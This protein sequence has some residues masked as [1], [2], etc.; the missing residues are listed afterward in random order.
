MIRVFLFSN[1]RIPGT[2]FSRLE[3]TGEVQIERERASPD[4]VLIYSSVWNRA[5]LQRYRPVLS[6]S[7]PAV[8]V[9]ERV[10]EPF[11][12]ESVLRKD[13]A[14]IIPSG[15]AGEPLVA[16]LRAAKAG[17]RIFHTFTNGKHQVADNISLTP[18]E[19]EVLTLIADG[20]G[21]KTIAAT[22]EISEHTVKFHISS[23]FDKLRVSTRT[24][25]VKV[26]VS[27]GLIS[28]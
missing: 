18:R 12:T 19:L 22:L 21:N 8:V 10:E 26:G 23:I 5:A 20:E 9:C 3:G 14:G 4:V 11:A 17:L 16:G 15:S 6:E 2:L 7:G 13:I 25:A 27:H 24:E 28:I 1:E